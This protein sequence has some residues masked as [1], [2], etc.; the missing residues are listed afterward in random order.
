MGHKVFTD[1]CQVIKLFDSHGGAISKIIKVS[2][3]SDVKL[4]KCLVVTPCNTWL[5]QHW[6]C[7]QTLTLQHCVQLTDTC[8]P[9][10]LDLKTFFACWTSY[11]LN[12]PWLSWI[13]KFM[14]LFRHFESVFHDGF[15][16]VGFWPK[17]NVKRLSPSK[18]KVKKHKN[19]TIYLFDKQKC[20]SSPI[21]YN[22]HSEVQLKLLDFVRNIFPHLPKRVIF[23]FYSRM[24]R[25]QDSDA[26]I[27][28]QRR[29][30]SLIFRH[31]SKCEIKRKL[32]D[33]SL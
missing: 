24:Y 12:F 2:I 14:I 26:D 22:M 17:G 28:R 32:Q 9:F 11:A 27:A 3:I 15:D 20:K 18:V 29:R 31:K 33:S 8:H 7:L 1:F 19:Y 23:Q 10:H 6:L 21:I 5:L 4:S 13:F 30:V 16:D 25:L